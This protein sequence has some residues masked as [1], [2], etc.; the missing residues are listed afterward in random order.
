MYLM[1]LNQKISVLS[2]I[3]CL[4]AKINPKLPLEV[5]VLLSL[6]PVVRVDIVLQV[7]SGWWREMKT[8]GPTLGCGRKQNFHSLQPHLEALPV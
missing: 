3:P 6:P 2:C 4:S 7:L 5:T 1:Y 8:V